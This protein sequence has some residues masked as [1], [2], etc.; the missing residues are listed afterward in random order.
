MSLEGGVLR[1]GKR[2]KLRAKGGGVRV[3]VWLVF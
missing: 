2:K 1:S 3:C